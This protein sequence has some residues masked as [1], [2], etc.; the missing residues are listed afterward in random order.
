MAGMGINKEL[1]IISIKYKFFEKKFIMA[2]DLL[3]CMAKLIDR[4]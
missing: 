2:Q 3:L 4:L 1:L